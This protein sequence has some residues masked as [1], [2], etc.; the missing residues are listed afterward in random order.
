MSLK[1]LLSDLKEN[2]HVKK[3]KVPS[4]VAEASDL[5]QNLLSGVETGA[6]AGAGATNNVCTEVLKA[7]LEVA[8]GVTDAAKARVEKLTTL[9]DLTKLSHGDVLRKMSVEF[10]KLENLSAQGAKMREDELTRA[11]DMAIA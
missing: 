7:A 8:Q 1:R 2:C 5:A 10:A 3:S 6:S 4:T 9:P 11:G